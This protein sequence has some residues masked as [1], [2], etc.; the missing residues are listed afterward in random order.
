MK[1]YPKRC[2]L[3]EC[4]AGDFVNR[5]VPGAKGYRDGLYGVLGITKKGT[6]WGSAGW[7][8]LLDMFTMQ[9]VYFTSSQMVAMHENV[10]QERRLQ[11]IPFFTFIE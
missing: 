4:K 2:T 3:G 11:L 8:V 7:H 9:L 10:T 6:G 1:N 5:T